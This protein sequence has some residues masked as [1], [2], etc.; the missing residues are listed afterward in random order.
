MTFWSCRKSRLIR[1]IRLRMH[2]AAFY[3]TT[4]SSLLKL[5]LRCLIR[6]FL[7]AIL[8]QI[9]TE[10][11]RSQIFVFLSLKISSPGQFLR[12]FNSRRYQWT[13][14]YNLKFRDLEAK[15]CVAFLLFQFW[16]EFWRFKV[17]ES[18]HF[19]K[20]KYKLL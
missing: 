1:K 20:Q 11:L 3:T 7:M 5:H 14:S 9:F 10:K 6:F 18:M 12:G 19:V 8:C 15:M 4:L 16:K 13:S 17:K 2:Y